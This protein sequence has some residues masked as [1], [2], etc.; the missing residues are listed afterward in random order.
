M[1]NVVS[2]QAGRLSVLHSAQYTEHSILSIYLLN[3]RINM[4]KNKLILEYGILLN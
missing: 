1:C 4:W 2:K 3:G